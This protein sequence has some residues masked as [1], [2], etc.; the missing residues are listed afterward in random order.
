MSTTCQCQWCG[1]VFYNECHLRTWWKYDSFVNILWPRI[2][3]ENPRA[4][5][6]SHDRCQWWFMAKTAPDLI[7]LTG[8]YAGRWK[9]NGAVLT[10]RGPNIDDDRYSEYTW[11]SKIQHEANC[12]Q[13]A[14]AM[15][16]SAQNTTDISNNHTATLARTDMKPDVNYSAPPS[17][18]SAIHPDD[19]SPSIHQLCTD[20]ELGSMVRDV[21]RELDYRTQAQVCMYKTESCAKGE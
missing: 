4:P 13:R 20:L 3:R 1:E 11:E 16:R 18:W 17:E 21:L 10:G 2:C 14:L 6:L 15:L 12:P 5:S 7:A 9:R 19:D 8:G